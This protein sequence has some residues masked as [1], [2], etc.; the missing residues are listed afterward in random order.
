MD[1]DSTVETGA[2]FAVSNKE[3]NSWIETSL[4]SFKPVHFKENL[5]E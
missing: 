4:L 2:I 1:H 5:M 3:K